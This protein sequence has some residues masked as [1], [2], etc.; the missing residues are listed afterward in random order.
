MRIIAGLIIAALIGWCG[1]WFIGS[2]AQKDAWIN[3]FND[4]QTAG[5][6]AENSDITV[7]GFPNRFD[8][9]ISEFELADTT[10]GW[11]W[12]A[13]FFQILMQSY[14]PNHVIAVWPDTQKISGPNDTITL[15]ND[16][17]RGSV[18]F[19]P[20]TDLTLDKTQI[21]IAGLGLLGTGWTAALESA[22]F[23]TRRVET[24]DAPDFAHQIGLDA[25][26]L[27]LSEPL[28]NAL[29]PTGILPPTIERGH[30]DIT[31]AFDAPWDRHS[32]EGQKPQLTV[33]SVKDIDVTWG[34]LNLQANGLLNIDPQGY[35][36][37]DI[38][39]K[40]RNWQEMLNL[41]AAS[42]LISSD[43]ARTVKDGLRLL[44]A[45][46]GDGNTL[47][48][49]LTFAGGTIRLGPIPIGSAPRMVFD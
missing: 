6:V 1:W 10:S 27:T 46:G 2:S 35:P 29:D 32:V 18:I 31:A 24:G 39:L 43:I 13:P 36:N 41:A 20:N 45:L 49:P 26:N 23:A 9:T 11:A 21:E 30:L 3:W 17:M 33:M 8:T 37:G 44:S 7:R 15:T 47:N 48:V 4:R 5:W 38:K 14:Q 25:R 16:K 42:G 22:N 19:L 12:S 34:E 40:M 28:K